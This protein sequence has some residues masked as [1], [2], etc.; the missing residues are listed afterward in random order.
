M[1]SELIVTAQSSSAISSDINLVVDARGV[2]KCYHI[3]DRPSHRLLQGVV[4]SSRRYYRE[5]WALRGAD[6]QV[7]RGQTVGLIGRNGSGK[8]TFLQMIAGT[9]TPTEGSIQVNGRVAAL[10]ELGSGFNPEFTGRENVYLNAAILGLSKEEVD[11]SLDRILAF[12]DIGAFIDQPIRSYSSGMVVRLAFAVQAQVHPQLL[13]VD[14]ALSVGDAKFQAKCFARLKQLKDD[15]ASILLVSHSADQIVQH[16]EFAQLLDSGRV[17]RHGRPK[18]VINAY[19]N[20]LFGSGDNNAPAPA[21][22]ASECSADVPFEEIAPFSGKDSVYE[23]RPSYNP[24]EFRW[25]DAA[26][27]ITDFELRSTKMLYPPIV[28]SGQELRLVVRMA[29]DREVIRPIIGFTL[30]TAEGVVVYGT[31]SEYKPLPAFSTSG[32]AGST[33][34]VMAIFRCDL[35]D[36]D[37]FLSVGVASRNEEDVVPHDRRYDSIHFKVINAD[38]FGM[39]GLDMQLEMASSRQAD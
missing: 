12:A 35:A 17:L 29:F 27:R 26:V 15:G 23:L 34:D 6:L 8:S 28:E 10:L 13:I 32:V 20:L 7:R 2:G 11:A 21:D 16:C 4:G 18:D 19:Y 30:K 38:F 5:F 25:G 36:G 14:E 39:G 9:L 24:H 22:D 31:N 37:Y 33:V 1:S 3:Y